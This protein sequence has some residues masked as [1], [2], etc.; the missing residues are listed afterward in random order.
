MGAQAT[1]RL[2]RGGRGLVGAL[3]GIA[4]GVLASSVSTGTPGNALPDR[5]VDSVPSS[6]VQTVSGPVAPLQASTLTL[7]A[8]QSVGGRSAT[9]GAA[10]MT[11]TDVVSYGAEMVATGRSTLMSVDRSHRR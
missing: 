3:A 5:R 11:S 7:R 9:A 10:G 4:F 1:V 2:R 6:T 8:P